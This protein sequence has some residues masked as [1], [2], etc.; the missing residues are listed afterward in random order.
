MKTIKYISYLFV[1]AIVLASC[2]NESWSPNYPDKYAR[3]T[4]K[5]IEIDVGE[6]AKETIVPVFDSEETAAG[7]FIWTFSNPDIVRAEVNADHSITLIGLVPGKS[8]VTLESEDGT[9]K[10]FSDLVISPAYPFEVPI[11]IDLGSFNWQTP[12]TPG[13]Y[14]NNL[15]DP[16]GTAGFAPFKNSLSNMKDVNETDS[17]YTIAVDGTFKIIDRDGII[18]TGVPLSISRDMFFNDGVEVAS[19][20]L[21]ISGLKKYFKYSFMIAHFVGGEPNAQ[22]QYDIMG[23]TTETLLVKPDIGLPAGSQ[24]ASS[25]PISPD[26][27]GRITVKVTYGPDNTQGG[28][29][30]GISFMALIPEGFTFTFP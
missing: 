9:L 3:I 17:K 5:V 8:M 23:Q 28:R 11:L 18:Y 21:V 15:T 19:A 22:S 10:Y 14:V 16:E 13:N 20:N 2:K 27:N 1:A 24:F 12:S 4:Q 6:R 26:A 29:F 30:Y 25:G 7:N